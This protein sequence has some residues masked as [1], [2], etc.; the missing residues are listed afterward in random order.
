MFSSRAG[1]TVLTGETGAGKTMVV[2]SLHLLSGARADAGRVRVGA[3]RAVVEGRFT[4]DD[5][6][7]SAAGAVAEL[8]ESSGAQRDE[9]ES[10][11]AARTV[12]SDGRSRAHLGG[13]SVPAGVLAEFT[14]S[15]LTVHG[16]NDQLR[17]QKPEQQRRALDEF[18][19]EPVESRLATY[20]AQRKAW[21]SARL[22]LTERT[23]RTRELA[24][25]ADR[26]THALVEIDAVS[27]L[28]GEDA[29]LLAS[30]RR[31]SDLDMLRESASE[32]HLALAGDTDGTSGVLDLLGTVRAR[33]QSS[34][35]PALTALAERV[36]EV[37]AIAG[38]IA[39]ELGDYLAGLPSDS[40]RVGNHA[41]SPG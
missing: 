30:I 38:D 2:T 28:P 3:S 5:L 18:A 33:V 32:A 14:S 4:T 15:L 20:R 39:A 25:E 7:E 36:E 31:L 40:V 24:Q 8:L 34:T 9:D 11:I 37:V 19:G 21:K 12:N 23:A 1:L 26:L 41:R 13:R 22:E 16:Q 29:D 10:V 6:H 17:L 35:D 27:P